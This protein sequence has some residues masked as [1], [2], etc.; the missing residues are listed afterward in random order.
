MWVSFFTGFMNMSFK[1]VVSSIGTLY[2]SFS[3]FWVTLYGVMLWSFSVAHFHLRWVFKGGRW[4][5]RAFIVF[6]SSCFQGF[7]MWLV[8]I[9]ISWLCSPPALSSPD[10][11]SDCLRFA[12]LDSIPGSFSSMWGFVLEGSLAGQVESGPLALTHKLSL[13]SLS[14]FHHC[15]QTGPCVF[16]WEFPGCCWSQLHQ[17][18][19]VPPFKQIM[20]HPSFMAAIGPSLTFW[21]SWRYLIS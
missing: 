15:S 17:L 13:Q 3:F 11:F 18:S 9:E 2:C 21:G 14:H 4:V 20:I 8:L 10:P 6:L 5:W 19:Q 16:W 7:R 12:H 1:Y